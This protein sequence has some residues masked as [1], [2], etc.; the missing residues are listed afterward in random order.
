MPNPI[1]NQGKMIPVHGFAPPADVIYKAKIGDPVARNLEFHAANSAGNA[2]IRNAAHAQGKREGFLDSFSAGV[3][4]FVSNLKNMVMPAP[5]NA[6][7]IIKRSAHRG[8]I[9]NLLSKMGPNSMF[10]NTSP[11]AAAGIAEAGNTLLS[12][13][14]AAR[15]GLLKNVERAAGQGRITPDA[16]PHAY[17]TNVV[18]KEQMIPSSDGPMSAVRGRQWDKGISAYASAAKYGDKPAIN[19][20][21]GSLY[22]QLEGARTVAGKN[23]TTISTAGKPQWKYGPVSALLGKTEGVDSGRV[24]NKVLGT[25]VGQILPTPTSEGLKLPQAKVNMFYDPKSVVMDASGNINAEGLAKARALKSQGALPLNRQMRRG[26][27]SLQ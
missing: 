2:P 9:R 25:D 13:L 23:A 14:E 6:A 19:D 26:M 18:T 21:W 3:G 5:A 12:P 1:I 4:N 10:H 7:P 15:K 24:F 22:D 8:A 16:V 17:G 20:A 11:E 27:R